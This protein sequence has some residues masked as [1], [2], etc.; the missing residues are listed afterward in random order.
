MRKLGRKFG[1]P[2]SKK[3]TDIAII[4][5]ITSSQAILLCGVSADAELLSPAMLVCVQN[6]W[7]L[8][9]KNEHF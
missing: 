1:L 9:K 2:K 3:Q 8:V 6:S 4:K 7:I 5:A